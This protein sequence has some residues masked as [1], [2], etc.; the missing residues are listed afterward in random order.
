MAVRFCVDLGSGGLGH[1][2]DT[3]NF[4]GVVHTPWRTVRYLDM[5]RRKSREID[6]LVRFDANRATAS[7]QAMRRPYHF[8]ACFVE[9][10]LKCCGANGW[11]AFRVQPPEKRVNSLF[12][13]AEKRDNL[14][15]VVAGGS[16]IF[17]HKKRLLSR[18]SMTKKVFMHGFSLVKPCINMVS[19]R[20]P[21]H[22]HV[23]SKAE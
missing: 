18:F 21:V 22:Q 7:C 15:T 1:N 5:P 13:L 19:Q 20:K 10:K 17:L 4:H 2:E 14:S 8:Q 9:G 23:F 6:W 11:R 3:R 12:Y 16:P